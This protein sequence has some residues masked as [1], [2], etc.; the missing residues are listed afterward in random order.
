MQHKVKIMYAKENFCIHFPFRVDFS[1]NALTQ[2]LA[3]HTQC[4]RR[5]F[6]TVTL[7][8]TQYTSE[9]P[10]S[11]FLCVFV[12]KKYIIIITRQPSAP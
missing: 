7:R 4:D 3:K 12:F 6:D 1:F 10:K 8:G 5:T 11:A 9:P 2:A